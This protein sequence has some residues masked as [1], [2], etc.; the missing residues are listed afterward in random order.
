MIACGVYSPDNQLVCQLDIMHEG[1]HG[2]DGS[3]WHGGQ[4]AVSSYDPTQAA[5]TLAAES[6]ADQWY[7]VIDSGVPTL[8]WDPEV[9]IPPPPW[10]GMRRKDKAPAVVAAVPV[11]GC[12]HAQHAIATVLTCGCWLPLWFLAALFGRRRMALVDKRGRV[13][14]YQRI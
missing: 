10:Q 9:E 3:Q 11:G 8:P 1:W 2:A 6:W 14:G 4:W 13:V 7:G 12:N 5:P